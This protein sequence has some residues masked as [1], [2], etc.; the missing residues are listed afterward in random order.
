MDV[1]HFIANNPREQPLAAALN[2]FFETAAGEGLADL[3]L[4]AVI[5]GGLVLRVRTKEGVLV[6]RHQFAAEDSQIVLNKIRQ[7]ANLSVIDVRSP[8]DGRIVQEALGRRLDVRVSIVP[9]IHGESCVMR[10]L[11]SA[12]AGMSIDRLNMPQKVQRAF[13]RVIQLPE[14]VILTVGPTGSGKTTTLYSAL[15][16]LNTPE[17]KIA[18]AENPV[19]YVLPGANQTPCGTG[20]GVTFAQALRAFLRQDPDIILVGEIRDEETAEITMQAGQTGHIVLS[21]LHANDALEAFTRLNELGVTAHVMRSAIKAVIAQRLVRRVCPLCARQLPLRD[22]DAIALAQKYGDSR[23]VET[24]GAGC[25]ACNGTGLQGRQAVYEMLLVDRA[26]RAAMRDLDASHLRETASQQA[27]YKPLAG[28]AAALAA[29][30][31]ISYRE[32]TRAVSDL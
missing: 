15:G 31:V 17:N 21:T 7:R 5:N 19:E 12:N 23:G 26:M 20:T 29:Q 16:I 4:E 3:H 14:G 9:T 22:E 25:E 8:Q 27:Q 6:Q 28:A 30:G 32:A 18:T 2:G 13:E 24:V 1:T 11:D 10:V